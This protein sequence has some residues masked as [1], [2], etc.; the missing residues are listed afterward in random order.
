VA[1]LLCRQQ[2]SIA[3]EGQHIE[4]GTYDPDR[5]TID[6][7]HGDLS[8]ANALACKAWDQK[9]AADLQHAIESRARQSIQST[10]PIK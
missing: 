6:H 10:F 2:R 4:H 3:L 8:A 7:F 1:I 9:A 5:P